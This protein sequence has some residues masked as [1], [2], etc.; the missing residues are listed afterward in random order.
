MPVSPVITRRS[1]DSLESYHSKNLSREDRQA[2]NDLSACENVFFTHTIVHAV[3]N[4]ACNKSLEDK[5]IQYLSQLT[6]SQ[7]KEIKQKLSIALLHN[8]LNITHLEELIEPT[9][10]ITQSQKLSPNEFKKELCGCGDPTCNKPEHKISNSG[11]EAKTAKTNNLVPEVAENAKSIIKNPW[12][13]T[14]AAA[15]FTS[16]FTLF[17]LAAKNQAQTANSVSN[18]D[19][20]VTKTDFLNNG[21]T[22][23]KSNN[24]QNLAASSA[25]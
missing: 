6:N 22:A 5:L 8:K 21:L 23:L 18:P 14:G 3:N 19:D 24:K 15:G 2:V 11:I 17:Y 7:Q 20:L 1:I 10:Q 13:W 12:F 25:I 16:M 9:N 4:N